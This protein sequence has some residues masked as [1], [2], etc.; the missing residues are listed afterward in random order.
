MCW[1]STDIQATAHLHKDIANELPTAQ[2]LSGCDTVARLWGIG[3][4]KV[5]KVLQ[6]SGRSSAVGTWECATGIKNL[7]QCRMFGTRYGN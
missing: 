7:Q 5:V 2:A 1:K 3:K 6:P 4:T